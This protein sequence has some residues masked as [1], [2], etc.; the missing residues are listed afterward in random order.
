M[1]A[2]MNRNLFARLNFLDRVNPDFIIIVHKRLG[3]R[4]T[5]VIGVSGDVAAIASING[6]VLI[7]RELVH[8]AF[9]VSLFI[10]H[11]PANVLDDFRT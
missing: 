4:A 8:P 1:L 5:G 11:D 2:V 9:F 7:D 3:V 10:V 6:L